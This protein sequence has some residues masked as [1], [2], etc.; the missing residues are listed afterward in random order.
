MN[1]Q[2]VIDGEDGQLTIT[3]NGDG[4]IEIE[5]FKQD[6][7]VETFDKEEVERLINFLNN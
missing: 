6:M 1:E 7:L 4:T 3:K 5:L 2:L